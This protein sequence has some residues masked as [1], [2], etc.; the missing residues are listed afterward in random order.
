MASQLSDIVFTTA[1]Q[2]ILLLRA[3]AL[4]NRSRK[5]LVFL[6]V[7]FVC[8]IIVI[9]VVIVKGINRIATG[10]LVTYAVRIGSVVDADS[11]QGSVLSLWQTIYR[12]VELAFDILLLV[13]ALFG[14]VKHALE[15]GGWSVSPL[16]KAMAEDQIV[17]FVWYAAW[18]GTSLPTTSSAD[19]G[20][21]L[22]AALNI[23]FGAFAII[24]GPHMVISL[25]VR[26]LKT[27][28]STLQTQLST[29]Q[30]N[31]R[32]PIH[33]SGSRREVDSEG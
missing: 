1:M 6:L 33:S 24:A 29:I 26:D 15:V 18:Q 16:V 17:Y 5:V 10:W 11:T 14:S 27:R 23:L 20:Y 4:C 32:E 9:V 13:V 31:P 19:A 28:E 25:R 8:E 30:F 22:L 12:A 3:H 2:A 7:S 21:P